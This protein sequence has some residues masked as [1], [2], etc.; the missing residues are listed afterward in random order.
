MR[1]QVYSAEWSVSVTDG[2]APRLSILGAFLQ[3]VS[4]RTQ[5]FFEGNFVELVLHVFVFRRNV[6]LQ[7]WHN[8]IYDFQKWSAYD[9][10]R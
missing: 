2:I 6:S 3:T 10:T 1:E 5:L 4:K 9:Q 7:L 8:E